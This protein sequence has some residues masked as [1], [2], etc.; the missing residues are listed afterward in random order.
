MTA[1]NEKKWLYADVQECGIVANT[2]EIA[3]AIK[4]SHRR[5]IA[6]IESYLTNH[7]DES[8]HFIL[9]KHE[10]CNG[11]HYKMYCLTKEGLSI[12]LR[13]R[14][15]D[16][17]RNS[18]QTVKGLNELQRLL[19]D[20]EP[21][22]EIRQSVSI[23]EFLKEHPFDLADGID[24]L[25]QLYRDE[26][27]GVPDPDNVKIPEEKCESWAKQVS[28]RRGENWY[29]MME[30]IYEYGDSRERNGYVAG[31]YMA[32]RIVAGVYSADRE[33]GRTQ[34]T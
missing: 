5:V 29:D 25:Y 14:F 3:D 10:V 18:P 4:C 21:K 13:L 27:N 24:K 1:T 32:F 16:A 33:F 11:R 15:E 31:F 20:G 6:R 28:K 23:E 34:K 9:S 12:Y 30:P 7:P 26:A 17:G 19:E 2:V 22:E 8:R